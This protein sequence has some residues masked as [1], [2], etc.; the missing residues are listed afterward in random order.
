[1]RGGE[2][3]AVRI[4]YVYSRHGEKAGDFKSKSF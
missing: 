2:F 1:M 4:F 3:D